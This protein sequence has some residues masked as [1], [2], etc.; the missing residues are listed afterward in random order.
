MKASPPKADD[1]RVGIGWAVW[2]GTLL[3]AGRKAWESVRMG[4][5]GL[6]GSRKVTTGCGGRGGWD[7]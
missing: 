4:N 5:G 6:S 2:L 1:C 3:A 7:T